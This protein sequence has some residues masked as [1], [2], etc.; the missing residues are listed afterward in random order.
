M[1]FYLNWGD[2]RI[3]ED[4]RKFVEMQSAI[5]SGALGSSVLMEDKK[6]K[7]ATFILMGDF[8]SIFYLSFKTSR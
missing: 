6:L 4:V 5:V 2:K 7:I 3:E 1:S 8:I